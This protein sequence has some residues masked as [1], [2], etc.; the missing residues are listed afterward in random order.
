MQEDARIAAVSPPA[1]QRSPNVVSRTL[2]SPS[3]IGKRND[4]QVS[5]YEDAAVTAVASTQRL[6]LEKWRTRVVH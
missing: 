4:R 2:L 3:D 5:V 6:P 1:M